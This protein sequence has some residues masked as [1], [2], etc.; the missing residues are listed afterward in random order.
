MKFNISKKVKVIEESVESG[1]KEIRFIKKRLSKVGGFKFNILPES[2]SEVGKFDVELINRKEEIIGFAK[3]G[4][5]GKQEELLQNEYDIL[6]ILG[7]YDFDNVIVPEI[8]EEYS[9]GEV[10][11]Q[12]RLRKFDDKIDNFKGK[13]SLALGELAKVSYNERNIYD[14]DCYKNISILA[15]TLLPKSIEITLR[16]MSKLR[17]NM[18]LQHMNL[19][20]EYIKGYRKKLY[21]YNWEYG[22]ESV[23]YFDI[24]AYYF[25]K[26]IEENKLHGDKLIKKLKDNNDV[27]NSFNKYSGDLTIDEGILIFLLELICKN[28][29]IN[30]KQDRSLE[31]DSVLSEGIRLLKKG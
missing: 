17:I 14:L 3:I 12:N 21:I 16:K 31:R 22:G 28:Y 7:Y 19:S 20:D 8:I 13:L 25:R 23:A 2:N 11:S 4:R 26:Y 27:M 6:K 24:M 15:R 5:K 1:E 30:D 29:L 9:N 18:S 10:F